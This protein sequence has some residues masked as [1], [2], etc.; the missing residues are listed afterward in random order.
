MANKK[1]Q[2]TTDIFQYVNQL[3]AIKEDLHVEL[4]LFNKNYTVYE[5]RVSE[6]VRKQ[7]M[8]TFV[9]ELI[10]AVQNGLATG[11]T[12]RDISFA[13]DMENIIM[14]EDLDK[15]TRAS[16]VLEQIEDHRD[17]IVYFN[18]EEH[19]FKRQK[20]FIARVTHKSD[21]KLKFHIVKLID[22]TKIIS[23]GIAWQYDSDLIDTMKAA[24]SFRVPA[25]NQTV[26]I[27][28]DIF[29]F[30][31]SKFEKTF[32]YDFVK[33]QKADKKAEQ[34]VKDFK[35]SVNS[36]VGGGLENI[37]RESNALLNKFLK[38]DTSLMKQSQVVELADEM[39]L[40]LMT[41]D[42]GAII[43]M[44]KAD[45]NVLLDIINDNYYESSATG[46][47]YVAKSKKSVEGSG[48]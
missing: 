3:D 46:N 23:G 44:E 29:A 15:V 18:E 12:V 20:G 13:E 21:R 40:E 8:Q 7:I 14:R 9:W 22:S 30:N 37:L 41:D 24:V 35:I 16:V 34:F 17:D 5:T 36:D 4:F 26:I 43:I 38:T 47:H 2:E 28:K 39:G 11:M 42:N 25:D 10:N 48:A 45:L 33:L 6:E 31:Q 32:N 27:N 1:E 19:E